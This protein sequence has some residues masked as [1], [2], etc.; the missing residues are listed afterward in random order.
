[1]CHHGPDEQRAFARLSQLDAHARLVEKLSIDELERKA[2]ISQRRSGIWT[3]EEID[4][5]V[6]RGVERCN[7][8]NW[9]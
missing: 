8:I 1:M 2:K 3:Q 6:R 5:A 9:D 4:L 7:A